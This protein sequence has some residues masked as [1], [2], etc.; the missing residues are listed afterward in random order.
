MKQM[1]HSEILKIALQLEKDLINLDFESLPIHRS[2][3]S[4]YRFDL[5]KI[6]YVSE[7]NAFI[8]FHILNGLQSNSVIPLIIDHGAGLG[9]F[10]FL[11]KRLG[12]QCI[13]HDISKEYIDGIKI[14][15]KEL[16]AEPDHFVT[17][18]TDA[19]IEYCQTYKLKP[20]GLGSR[21]VIEHIPD[22][23]QFFKD[24]RE[25]SQP[26]FIAVITTSANMHNPLVKKL[27]ENIHKQYEYEGS[28]T[29]MDNPTLNSS[30]SGI[31][32][33]S[34]I[35]R[36]YFSGL[37][38]KTV[39]MLAELN[40]G[41]TKVEIIQRT[42]EFLRTNML[43]T[44]H[45]EPTNTR[46]PYSGAW[47]ERLVSY[48]DYKKSAESNSFSFTLLPGFYNTHYS[49]GLKNIFSSILNLSLKIKNPWSVNLSPFL[50]MKME[51]REEKEGVKGLRG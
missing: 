37:D 7:C 43:P 1:T 42:E 25:L 35:I 30:N 32:I 45:H 20:D 34:E 48:N 5:S 31:K 10:S 11:I 12:L 15:G 47:V 27:H 17:G 39:Y 50:A 44:L 29:D 18:D 6:R 14:I 8:L 23:R 24:L 33:R 26:G 36:S 3:K 38:E 13:C 16:Y 4:Y 2:V 46:D 49:S 21:N 9:F 22:Y 41:F 28:S 51:R 19:L 40:R